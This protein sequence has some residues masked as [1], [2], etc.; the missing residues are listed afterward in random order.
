M[1]LLEFEVQRVGR[2]LIFTAT[3]LFTVAFG[4]AT[5][6]QAPKTPETC[7]AIRSEKERLACYDELFGVP[8][9]ALIE[10]TPN[11]PAT[12]VPEPKPSSLLDQR[13]ELS[14]DQKQG[15]FRV[16]PNKPVYILAAFH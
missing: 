15:S 11:P 2:A 5:Q 12:A 16:N 3:A 4:T 9:G 1:E 14:P 7:R 13:W 6:A 10:Q 8:E